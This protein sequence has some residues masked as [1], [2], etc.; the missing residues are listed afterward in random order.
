MVRWRWDEGKRLMGQEER[1]KWRSGMR[2]GGVEGWV[3][4]WFG[5]GIL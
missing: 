4:D 3:L 2:I 5:C 1:G